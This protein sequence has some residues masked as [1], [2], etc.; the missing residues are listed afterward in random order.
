MA[1]KRDYYEVL[2]KEVNEAYEVLSDKE[3]RARYDRFGF[4]G[5]DPN[6]GAGSTAYGGGNPFGQDIDIGDKLD[7]YYRT[8]D[9]SFCHPAFLYPDYISNALKIHLSIPYYKDSI[10]QSKL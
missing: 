4:A 3:K 6:Y 1:D 10:F 2:V 8:E 7:I 9:P 5:V